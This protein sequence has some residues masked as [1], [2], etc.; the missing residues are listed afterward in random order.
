MSYAVELAEDV[1]PGEIMV[2]DKG[3]TVLVDPKAVLFLIGAKHG[4]RQIQAVGDLHVPEP[5]R[6]R[7]LRLRGIRVAD[8][9]VP[10]ERCG[11]F[12]PEPEAFGRGL[13]VIRFRNSCSIALGP[14]P[15]R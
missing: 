14:Y 13:F 15:I 11:N 1:R 10:E 9:R 5:Q 12:P 4:F 7:V 2:E 8:R 6:N 3:A